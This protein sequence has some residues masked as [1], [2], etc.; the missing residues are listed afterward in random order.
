MG[1]AKQLTDRFWNLFETN[2]LGEMSELIEAD[3]HFKMPGM[4][5]HGRAALL[6]MLT[7][8]RTAFPDLRHTVLHHVEAGDTIAI[9]L[10]VEGTHTGPMQMPQGSVPATGNKVVWESCDYVRLSNGKIGSWHVYHDSVPFLAALGLMPP[11]AA[12]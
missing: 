1:H 11:S 8:Y 9:E 10:R 2:Q 12:R 6:Q 4:D 7:A 3:C 5:L